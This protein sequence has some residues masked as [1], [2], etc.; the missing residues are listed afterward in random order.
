[1]WADGTKTSSAQGTTEGTAVAPAA[2]GKNGVPGISG[3]HAP[4]AFDKGQGRRGKVLAWQ[5][6]GPPPGGSGGAS[7]DSGRACGQSDSLS[8]RGGDSA[9]PAFQG[10]GYTLGGGEE[11]ARAHKG[12]KKKTLSIHRPW[13]KKSIPEEDGHVNMETKSRND[14]D[15][16]KSQD[17]LPEPLEGVWLRQHLEFGQYLSV[18]LSH[19]ICGCYSSFGK[20]IPAQPQVS[21]H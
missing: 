3:R 20:L 11:E 14:K 1:M 19:P 12:T 15:C 6:R 5:G 7:G 17:S 18:V 2:L 4:P 9:L 8:R 21:V 13:T 16:Q 10:I